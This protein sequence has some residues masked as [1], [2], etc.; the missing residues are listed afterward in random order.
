MLRPAR[1][2]V[3]WCCIVGWAAC[4]GPAA[5]PAPPAP[6]LVRPL[7]EAPSVPWIQQVWFAA[8]PGERVVGLSVQGT[9]ASSKLVVQL[10]GGGGAR[11]AVR[12]DGPGTWSPA[13]VTTRDDE[14]ASK[15]YSTVDGTMRASITTDETAGTTSLVVTD[16]RGGGRSVAVTD[17]AARHLQHP[18][19]PEGGGA[20]YVDEAGELGGIYRVVLPDGPVERIVP[21]PGAGRPVAWGGGKQP[22]IAY[23]EAGDVDRVL[24]ALPDTDAR[25][26]A[27]DV[28][29]EGRLPDT[30]WPVVVT[31]EGKPVRLAHCEP[32]APLVFR[33]AE[34]GVVGVVGVEEPRFA[35]ARFCGRGCTELVTGSPEHAPRIAARIEEDAAS[36]VWTTWF[37]PGRGLPDGDW[38]D[39]D[40]RDD[41]QT[42][43]ACFPPRATG[44]WLVAPLFRGRPGDTFSHLT[45]QADLLT[46]HA[47]KGK[48]P[49]TV[50]LSP[51]RLPLGR[52]TRAAAP[53]PDP[54]AHTA[55]GGATATAADGGLVW[56]EVATGATSVVLDPDPDRTL[57]DPTFDAAGALVYVVDQGAEPGLLR[58]AL[59]Q[60]RMER[61]LTGPGLRHPLP[62]RWD[63]SEQVAWVRETEGRWTAGVARPL[64]Q[65]EG[66]AWDEGPITLTDVMPKWIPV[67]QVG[68]EL[69]R[70]EAPDVVTVGIDDDG[71]F[72]AWGEI[73]AA[74]RAAAY[75]ADTLSI[76]G[77]DDGTPV[78]LAEL[79]VDGADARWFPYG[80]VAEGAERHA[81]RWL[82]AD[83]AMALPARD[84]PCDPRK[85]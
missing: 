5:P 82:A 1:L 64:T 20:V 79:R 50:T 71:G 16:T 19:V 24:V 28:Q 52:P 31:A 44:R 14:A 53:A 69:V 84:V 2:L 22:R 85:E 73:R 4:G 57:V 23:V 65:A 67:Q 74:A 47:A 68:G 34:G 6:T 11:R 41:L 3:P 45:S 15:S 10:V 35:T 77:D 25:R 54:V 13:Q 78:L 48:E 7:G 29:R 30:L 46:L 49:F 40:A 60:G 61:I 21:E 75:D 80:L 37:E 33:A 18:A 26:P 66:R 8:D 62:L 17:V 81:A 27:A 83:Q 32:D 70:C 42:V 36:G 55:D 12:L 56:G 59:E 9:G 51:R 72:V 43:P 38:V 39:G 76:L 58:I 63:G